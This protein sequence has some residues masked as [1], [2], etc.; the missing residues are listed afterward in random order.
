MNRYIYKVVVYDTKYGN[1]NELK[2]EARD[3][4]SARW[5]AE[6]TSPYAQV[7]QID[8]QGRVLNEG[9]KLYRKYF[10]Y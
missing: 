4:K 8:L 9:E 2:I 6:G 10:G 7:K 1:H 5:Q 3:E